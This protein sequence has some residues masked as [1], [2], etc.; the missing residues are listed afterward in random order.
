MDHRV[1]LKRSI[2]VSLNESEETTDPGIHSLPAELMI[3][4]FSNLDFKSLNMAALACKHWNALS[5]DSALLR[6]VFFKS[7]PESS[8][9]LSRSNL[10]DNFLWQRLLA[11][12]RMRSQSGKIEPSFIKIKPAAILTCL[13]LIDGNIFA[14]TFTGIISMFDQSGKEFKRLDAHDSNVTD[15]II[16][17]KK[18][19]S[20][21]A[22]STILIWD[23]EKE[24]TIKVLRGHA[25]S[26][27]KLGI[28]NG[29]LISTSYD[30]TLRLWDIETGNELKVL[31]PPNYSPNFC[32]SEGK[33]FS[34]TKDHK[35]YI[36]DAKTGDE[37]RVIEY[38]EPIERF[39]S[40][41]GKLLIALKGGVIHMLDIGTNKLK[42]LKGHT[43]SVTALVE[44]QG[45]I[46]SGSEDQTIRIWDLESGRKLMTLEGHCDLITHI[47]V[48]DK[49][50]ISW[51]RD[52]LSRF[53]EDQTIRLWDIETGRELRK[54]D[55]RLP[56][57]LNIQLDVGKII[58]GGCE[59]IQII[60]YNPKPQ[61]PII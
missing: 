34:F 46:F 20:S 6:T 2:I 48:L 38:H 4:I 13:K 28:F 60:D 5:K 47:E 29:I 44:A 57:L 55:K 12:A 32:L 14:G 51:S 41:K 50:I 25:D 37:I 7:F 26:V 54:F 39:I 45:K 49:N 35:L 24:E 30:E 9:T 1:D 61:N 43:K 19:F 40:S 22:D 21:S 15:I 52:P 8:K 53:S 10:D 59:S 31:A 27:T 58:G 17:Q 36:W 18:L 33:I 16:C 23:F 11:D 3:E 56:D 42:K